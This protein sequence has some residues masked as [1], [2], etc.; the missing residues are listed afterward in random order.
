MSLV[1]RRAATLSPTLKVRGV[2][3]LL[4]QRV[5]VTYSCHVILCADA[6]F[7]QKR[8]KSA[9]TD[10]PLSFARTRFATPNEVAA[11]EAEVETKRKRVPRRRTK[12]T[13]ARVDDTI[14]DECENSFLAAQEKMT[15]AT[16][17]YYADTGVMALLC[18]HDRVLFVVSMTTPGERQFYV[19]TLLRKA[20]LELPDDWRVGLLYDIGCQISRSIEKVSIHTFRNYVLTFCCLFSTASSRS[21]QIASSLVCRFS[22]LM[23]IT[24]DVSLCSIRASAMDLG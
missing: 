5:D 3:R 18:R 22:M 11:M 12:G 19:L 16:T 13:S 14:L 9:E 7:A 15:K 6:N 17:A 8:R 23:G 20:L 4:L 10:A 1:L 21:S 2:F 24:G